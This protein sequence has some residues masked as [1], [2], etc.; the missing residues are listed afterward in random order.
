VKP[1]DQTL[2]AAVQR[3]TQIKALP[4]GLNGSGVNLS[5]P[6]TKKPQSGYGSIKIS[7]LK[8]GFKL[9]CNQKQAAKVIPTFQASCSLTP[10]K[11]T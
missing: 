5:G 1:N 8:I 2:S 4:I 7:I 10:S 3:T 9:R 6:Q 11:L